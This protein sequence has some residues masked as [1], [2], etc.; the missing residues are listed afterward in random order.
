MIYINCQ[1][2]SDDKNNSVILI[3]EAA[4][5]EIPKLQTSARISYVPVGLDGSILSGL[6]KKI[7]TKYDK[8][9]QSN[10]VYY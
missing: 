1:I 9:K 5:S 6:S 10:I 2:G 8:L 4:T 3:I 7:F